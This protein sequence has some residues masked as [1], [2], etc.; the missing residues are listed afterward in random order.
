[1]T[2]RKSCLSKHSSQHLPCWILDWASNLNHNLHCVK[3]HVIPSKKNPLSVCQQTAS[4]STVCLV[5]RRLSFV[6]RGVLPIKYRASVSRHFMKSVGAWEA[7]RSKDLK[8]REWLKLD[9]QG[10]NLLI[11]VSLAKEV[12]HAIK[13]NSGVKEC[14]RIKIKV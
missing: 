14:V 5:P 4:R 7:G 13:L 12:F 1:M 3:Q 9:S 8:S 2:L 10:W 11:L 6:E